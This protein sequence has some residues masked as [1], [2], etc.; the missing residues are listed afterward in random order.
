MGERARDIARG[1]QEAGFSKDKIFS[2]P[3]LQEAGL[4]LQERLKE[5]DI[6]LIK[7]SRGIKMEEIV[8]E[9]MAEPWKAQELLVS[10][11]K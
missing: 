3:F 7:G 11:V 2:F 1:A 4:F 9:I 5:N 8:Y 6:V 10:K